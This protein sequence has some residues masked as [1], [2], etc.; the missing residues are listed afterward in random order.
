MREN[1]RRAVAKHAGADP[2]AFLADLQ[3]STRTLHATRQVLGAAAVAPL[4]PPPLDFSWWGR[5]LDQ[6]S[7]QD[8]CRLFMMALATSSSCA[9]SF[10][11]KLT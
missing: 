7:Y 1:T 4:C 9:P 6:A 11:L 8:F 2:G 10:V 5:L 3:L